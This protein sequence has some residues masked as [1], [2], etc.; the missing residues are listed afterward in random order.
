[1][2]HTILA[3]LLGQNKTTIAKKNYSTPTSS[4]WQHLSVPI[5]SHRNQQIKINHKGDHLSGNTENCPGTSVVAPT[6]TIMHAVNNHRKEL[7]FTVA[8]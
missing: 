3:I 1:M 6:T 2:Q 4:N 8:G 5:I 7:N